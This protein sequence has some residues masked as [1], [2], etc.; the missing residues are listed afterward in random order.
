MKPVAKETLLSTVERALARYR[1]MQELRTLSAL[2]A[3]FTPRQGEVFT[4]MTHGK[5]NRQIA[6]ELGTS[7]RTVKAHRQKIM[8][9]LNVHTRA[10]AVSIAERLG[11]V[12]HA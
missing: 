8:Q 3:T 6:Y 12:T 4:L 9:K 11:L 7:L 5:L 10:E 1:E 2:V